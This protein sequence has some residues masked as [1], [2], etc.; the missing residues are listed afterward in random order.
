MRQR[1]VDLRAICDKQS[2]RKFSAEFAGDF[3]RVNGSN[4]NFSVTFRRA[5]VTVSSEIFRQN[6]QRLIE[7][8]CIRSR[9]CGGPGT[10][11]NSNRRNQRPKQINGLGI[12]ATGFRHASH[13]ATPFYP[14]FCVA[15]IDR[16]GRRALRSGM[17]KYCPGG[18][19][20]R[21]TKVRRMAR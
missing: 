13:D 15:L 11:S 16:R 19:F 18:S 10:R 1:I 20:F 7:N 6:L 2:T 8:M 14:A 9:H 21:R 3:C 4:A 12:L 5:A 17:P